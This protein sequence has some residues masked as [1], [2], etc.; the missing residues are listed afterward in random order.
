MAATVEIIVKTIDE[1]SATVKKID[2]SFGTFLAT[3]A[4]GAA[5]LAAAGLAAKQAFDFAEY[6]AQVQQTAESFEYLIQ[7]VGAAP[8]LLEKLTEAS[9]GTVSQMELMASTTT[10]LAGVQ[11][12]VATAM[13]NS[14]PQLLEIAKAAN[15]LNPSLGTTTFMYESLA[16]GI[17]RAQPK[18]IDNLG[19]QLKM[20]DAYDNYARSIGKATSELNA[21]ERQ[22]AIVNETIRAGEILISQV[23]DS[24]E[25]TTDI[26]QQFEADIKDTKNALAAMFTTMSAGTV[27]AVARQ[28]SAYGELI[29]LVQDGT[30][31]WRDARTAFAE[32]YFTTT[33]LTEAVQELTPETLDLHSAWTKTTAQARKLAKATDNA[34]LS[35]EG[36]GEAVQATTGGKREGFIE[37]EVGIKTTSNLES[38]I[39]TSMEEWAFMANTEAQKIAGDF[40]LVKTMVESGDIPPGTGQEL[41]KELFGELQI[42]E[43]VGDWDIAK[44]IQSMFG[45]PLQEALD[46]T[47]ELRDEA[48]PGLSQAQLG[49]LSGQITDNINEPL[50]QTLALIAGGGAGEG[51]FGIRDELIA[52]DRQKFFNISD[53][54][55]NGVV[56]ATNEAKIAAGELKEELKSIDGTTIHIYVDYIETGVQP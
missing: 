16:L 11:G 29:Q 13:A 32:A 5:V 24:T 35:I 12:E 51:G 8:G 43:G 44:S 50:K 18:I 26:F 52:L 45:T 19:L 4:K 38:Q 28:T 7:K 22:L 10:L 27:G 36:I 39:K 55:Q 25:S 46:L 49:E 40:N 15:K 42:A 21:E 9:R 17:K 48:M 34:R 54:L 14:A 31:T 47:R 6:G 30:I 1:S 41:L 23:G 2:T 33:T 53:A 3:A 37:V 20:T 56:E